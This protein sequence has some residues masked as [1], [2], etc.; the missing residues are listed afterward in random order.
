MSLPT[1]PSS[2][3]LYV[4]LDGTLIRTDS[5][6][7]ALLML[8][9]RHPLTAIWAMAFVATHRVKVKHVIARFVRLEPAYLPYRDEVVT[10]V[11]QAKAQG[12]RVVL[13]TGSAMPYAQSVADHMGCFDAVFATESNGL[14]LISENKLARIR[15]DAAHHGE[16]GFEYLGDSHA[17]V[18]IF[19]QSAVAGWVGPRRL[20]INP[21]N[22]THV[23]R[24]V[25]VRNNRLRDIVRL[26]RPTWCI[27]SFIS[28]MAFVLFTTSAPGAWTHA[29]LASVSL[30]SAVS[31]AFV[32]G[33]LLHIATD[34][35]SKH[36]H[37]R[38]VADGSVTIKCATFVLLACLTVT[39]ALG[40]M[41]SLRWVIA[42]T[43]VVVLMQLFLMRKAPHG[44]TA[45]P[46][47]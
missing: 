12:R 7:Q 6:Q 17:D 34:Q 39:L 18:T 29:V 33:D 47:A 9:R 31:A 2:I 30:A 20:N 21:T 36:I 19:R 45:N 28:C 42:M 40:A 3:P 22:E 23:H 46:H 11:K 32:V 41:H 35:R 8:I 16:T 43:G 14:N 13:A 4:D 25:N 27:I 26:M 37:W 24:L 10:Y 1:A 5:M 44:Q 38:P 15:Q